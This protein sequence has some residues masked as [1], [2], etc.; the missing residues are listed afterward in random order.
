MR[1]LGLE[2]G[3]QVGVWTT[4]V[5]SKSRADIK[6]TYINLLYTGTWREHGGLGGRTQSA[7]T[8]LCTSFTSLYLFLQVYN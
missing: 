5:K 6:E 8:L 7:L 2:G 4:R 3:R 1:E